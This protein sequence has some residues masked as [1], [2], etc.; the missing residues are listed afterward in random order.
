M[1][2]RKRSTSFRGQFAGRLI[3]MLESPAHRALSLS[4]LRVICRLEIENAHH[5][6]KEN[7]HL[8][9]TYDD[10]E[11]FGVHRHAIRPAIQEAVALGFL[12]ITRQGR[13][14]NAEFRSPNYFR[15]TFRPAKGS[16]GNDG[17]HEW[18]QIDE[19]CARSIAAAARKAKP[20][21]TRAQWRKT[22]GLSGGSRHQEPSIHSAKTATTTYG[23]ETTTTFDISGREDAA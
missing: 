8:P 19:K 14:G 23:A 10:F 13:A 6:G 16:Y 18:R 2:S 5:G 1:S 22:T 21:K 3:E 4:A 9:V 11:R 12:E 15:L 20:E 17:T 7:G